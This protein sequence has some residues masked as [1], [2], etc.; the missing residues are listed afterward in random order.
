MVIVNYSTLSSRNRTGW[1]LDAHR[2]YQVNDAQQMKDN[3]ERM[4]TTLRRNV[5]NDEVDGQC[6]RVFGGFARRE[7]VITKRSLIKEICGGY[8]CKRE[9]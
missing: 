1:R 4:Y 8:M 6:G 2:R 3:D 9:E 5:E 7:K